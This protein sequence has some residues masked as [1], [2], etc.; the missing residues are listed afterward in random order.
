[1][2]TTPDHFL[3]IC[4]TCKGAAQPVAAFHEALARKLPAGFAIRTVDCMAGCDFPRAVGFQA[5]DKAQ[6]LFGGIETEE[7]IAALATFARQYQQ[8]ADGWTKASE[9]PKPL[10]T[11]T[12][13]RMP[14]IEQEVR[15]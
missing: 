11:K 15:I 13:S 12:L 10:F 5:A 4:A 1:M 6:Y 9:R 2:A 3:L 7:E 8:S 14:R